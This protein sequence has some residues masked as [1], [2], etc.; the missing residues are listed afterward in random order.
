ML[1]FW[2]C[3]IFPWWCLVFTVLFDPCRLSLV[4]AYLKEETSFLV[5]TNWFGQATQFPELRGFFLKLQFYWVGHETV[6]A[7]EVGFILC[8]PL[9]R[10]LYRCRSCLLPGLSGV[11]PWLCSLGWHLDKCSFQ[12]LQSGY[13]NV[14]LW[15]GELRGVAPI[16]SLSRQDYS[17]TIDGGGWAKLQDPFRICSQ[18]IIS[19]LTSTWTA[20]MR[21]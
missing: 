16:R 8:K 12:G 20:A 6:T 3:I 2:S 10:E 1:Y 15:P 7:S 21:G 5:F 14:D 13:L 4:S 18:T 11:P 9:S 17:L 19:E